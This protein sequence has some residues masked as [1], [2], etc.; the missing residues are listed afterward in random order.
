MAG[1]QAL[2]NQALVAVGIGGR[3]TQRSSL[4]VT[5]TRAQSS[6]ERARRS[7]KRRRDWTRR[8]TTRLAGPLGGQGARDGFGPQAVGEGPS[9]SGKD[10]DARG[11]YSSSQAP[12][13]AFQQGEGG[14]RGPQLP[15]A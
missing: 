1:E 8:W 10:L 4:R 6:S 13:G 11:P 9:R 5:V 3:P 15:A 12:P 2:A 7:V 14:R